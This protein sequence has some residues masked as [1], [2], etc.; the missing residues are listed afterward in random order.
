[1]RGTLQERFEARILPEPN[2]GCWLWDGAVDTTGH[3][4]GT[5]GFHKPSGKW[6]TEKAHRVSWMVY[7]GEIPEGLWVLHRCDNRVCVNPDHLFLGTRSDNMQDC[8]KK[9]RCKNIFPRGGRHFKAK[10]TEEDVRA[11]RTTDA[12]IGDIA[13]RYGMTKRN[14]YDIRSG[15][16]WRHV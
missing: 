10:I 12:R 1:M 3:G 15:A 9:G 11:I 8:S 14:V 6:G 5:L 16:T 4:Y 2:S 7:R 13:A